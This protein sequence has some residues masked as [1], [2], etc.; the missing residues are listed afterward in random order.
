MKSTVLAVAMAALMIICPLALINGVDADTNN[1]QTYDRVLV[2]GDSYSY[3]PTFNVTMGLTVAVSGTAADWLSVSG[4]ATSGYTISGTAPSVS[5]SGGSQSFVLNVTA[6]TTHPTQTATQTINFTV[7]DTLTVSGSKTSDIIYTGDTV[8]AT[9]SSNFTGVT[10]S[11]TNA[12]AGISINA[13]TGAIS[14]TVSETHTGDGDSKT[15]TSTVTATHAASYQSKSYTITFTMYKT[16]TLSGDTVAYAIKGTDLG[17]VMENASSGDFAQVSANVGNISYTAT[18]NNSNATGTSNKVSGMYVDSNGAINGL[19]SAS[20]DF[21]VV[22]TAHH[23]IS[24]QS[25]T[26]T[27]TLHAV[28]PLGFSNVPSG[29]IVVS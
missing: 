16:V 20:G 18:I 22:I 8:S 27:I 26:K 21:T 24:G 2:E 28:E 17:T 6:T 1:G 29:N 10:Y 7:Y 19:P 13:S 12:P 3:S 25:A 5:T 14:G 9:S 4:N 23:S 15:I 11:M